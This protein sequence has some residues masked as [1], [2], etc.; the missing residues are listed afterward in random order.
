MCLPLIKKLQSII[1]ESAPI[2]SV[3]AVILLWLVISE[4]E[5]VP[6]YMLPSP[7]EVVQVFFTDTAVLLKH[8][9]ITV[10]EALYGLL[11]GT[12]LGFVIAVVMDRFDFLYKSFYPLIVI[13]QTI[14]TI[15]IAPLLVLWMG[16]SMAPKITLVVLTTFFPIAVSLLDGFKSADKDEINLIR[17]M[18]GNRFQVF[19]HVKLPSAAEQFFSGLKVSASYS[20]VGAVISEWLGGFEG[21]GVYMT[22]VKKAYAF[23]KMFAVIILISALSLV[24]MAVINLLRN[25]VL[26]YKKEKLSLKER[27]VKMKKI[28]CILLAV[29][30][31][32]GGFALY[33]S[34]ENKGDELTEITL[35]LDWTPNTNHTG[36]FVADKLGYYEDA[37]IKI[38][39]VQPPENGAELMTASGQAQFGIS[40]QDTLADLFSSENPPEITS[41]AAIIQHNTSGI[42]TRK[43]EGATSPKGLEGMRYSTWDWSIEQ[44]TIKYLMEKDGGDY[45]KLQLIPNAVTNEAEAL[46]NKDT[47]AIWIY[48][49]WAGVACERA[50]LEFDYFALT[51]ID[52]VFDYYTP[53]IVANNAFL[54]ES[55]E[56]AKAFMQAT[57]KG[58]E[59]AVENPV[60]AAQLLVEGDTT[61]SL[62]GSIDF[63][64]ASQQWISEKYIDDAEEWGV[65]DAER[66]NSYYKWV[67]DEGLIAKE[68]P[69]NFGFT[70][71][72]I[73][74]DN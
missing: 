46:K 52:K 44:A 70:N 20:V 1:N 15:A 40:F 69:E 64:A 72:F 55:P 62:D 63:V 38:Q 5:L 56:I 36:F 13:S 25:S 45:S 11:I 29:I 48:Y 19:R 23:D 6:A 26:H 14:P 18:G 8:T 54:E 71:D 10:Q 21:L 34:R 43:G 32:I 53:V 24:L 12:A 27:S 28:V 33:N 31:V 37:G 73:K 58:Y 9:I 61:G 59:Y 65:F 3:V 67:Y 4:W 39:I 49:A 16:F 22:R 7:A 50:D 47:D 42:I 30:L 60:H 66:W 74:G 17:S 57:K 68:I 51:D 41:V 35:C 2:I